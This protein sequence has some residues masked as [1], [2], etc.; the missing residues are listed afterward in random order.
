MDPLVDAALHSLPPVLKPSYCDHST[1]PISASVGSLEYQR[2]SASLFPRSLA[3]PETLM[4]PF[5]VA[6]S[7]IFPLEDDCELSKS[8]LLPS[9]EQ[10]TPC[11]PFWLREDRVPCS[12][13]LTRRLMCGHLPAACMSSPKRLSSLRRSSESSYTPSLN[14]CTSVSHASCLVEQ[15]ERLA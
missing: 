13:L 9:P 2:C 10:L 4:T 15:K 6:L 8:T 1:T 14:A 11:V 7:P 12:G 3:V 5:R